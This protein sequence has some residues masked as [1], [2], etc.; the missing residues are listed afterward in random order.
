MKLRKPSKLIEK[1][2]KGTGREDE[3][4]G[5]WRVDKSTVEDRDRFKARALQ[6]ALLSGARDHYRSL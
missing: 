5:E 4:K 1:K 2:E 6:T 3:G